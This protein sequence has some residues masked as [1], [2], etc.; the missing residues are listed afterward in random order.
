MN[1]QCIS[2]FGLLIVDKD[3]EECQLDEINVFHCVTLIL[4]AS[5][6]IQ[7]IVILYLFTQEPSSFCRSMSSN[8]P[9]PSTKREKER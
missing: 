5:I 4:I 8:P 1:G 6:L 3:E 7:S 2:G 9:P